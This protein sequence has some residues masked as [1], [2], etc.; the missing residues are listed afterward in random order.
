MDVELASKRDVAHLNH[1]LKEGL[2]AIATALEK[3]RKALAIVWS[4]SNIELI[5]K[6]NKVNSAL[7]RMTASSELR[8][9]L[10]QKLFSIYADLKDDDPAID[11]LANMSIWYLED[12]VK[13]GLIPGDADRSE[14]NRQNLF[15]MV[16]AGL[17]RVNL[18]R[19]K[20]LKEAYIFSRQTLRDYLALYE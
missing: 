16:K 11:G 13:V 20:D 10:S 8:D 12:Y 17:E 14:G 7:Q 15:S 6:L 4:T 18:R 9:L 3:V 2:E 1:R 19:V 5:D